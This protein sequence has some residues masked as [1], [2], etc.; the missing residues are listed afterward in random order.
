MP[1][2][3]QTKQARTASATPLFGLRQ[4][5]LMLSLGC[6]LAG[7]LFLDHAVGQE[8]GT[9]Y[10]SPGEPANEYLDAVDRIESEYGPYATEL[11]DLYLGLG[12]TLINSG[13][14]EQA[15]DAFHRGVMVVRVNSGPNSPEQTNHLYMLANI[16]TLLGELKAA[17]EV[18]HNIHFINSNYYGDDSP[19]MLPVLERIYQWC[20]VTR[21]SD[22]EDSKYADYER[23]IEL[24]EEMVRVSEAAM[25]RNHP[26]TAVANRRLADAEFQ[27][28]RHLTGVGMTLTPKNYVAAT[29]GSLA[30]MGL[31][32][33]SVTE[34]YNDGRKAFRKYLELMLAIKS[35]TPLEY[36]EALADLGDWYLVFEKPRKSREIYETGYQILA[37]SEKY[38]ELADSYMSQPKPMH[39]VTYPQPDLFEDTPTELQEM[40]LDLSM[41]VTS[42]GQVRKV[43]VLNA[44]EG[45]S[46]GAL[47]AIER[48]LMGTP[49]RPAMK[50]GEVVTT[51]DFI[52]HY[53]I[54]PQ[55][56]AS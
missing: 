8:E 38:A 33:E 55:G 53:A 17:Y 1:V 29:G 37:R 30:P 45:M 15:R 22:P 2:N 41:T 54:A 46:K 5:Q 12:Q 3:Y 42:S 9:A 27:M 44:P 26:D 51:R 50:E 18:L 52:W 7:L 6:I 35:T 34:H 32:S 19:E 28:V 23:I 47:R 14:Y 56:R 21:P 31:G 39:F 43:E 25:G 4:R 20:L 24:T 36:A 11:S 16:E 40:S 10:V 49:F 48:Q 13:D